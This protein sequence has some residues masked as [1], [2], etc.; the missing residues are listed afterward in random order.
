MHTKL[1]MEG[2]EGDPGA[3]ETYQCKKKNLFTKRTF[4]PR[5]ADVCIFTIMTK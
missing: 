4:T 1:S 2:K 5:K 3:R